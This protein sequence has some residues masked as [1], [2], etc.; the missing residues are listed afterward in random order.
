MPILLIC[1]VL[2]SLSI[3]PA[4]AVDINLWH[5][6]SAAEPT[7]ASGFIRAKAKNARYLTIDTQELNQL[8]MR[9]KQ[10]KR[11]QI[12]GINGAMFEF[13]LRP[14]PVMSTAL[15]AHYPKMMSYSGHQVGNVSNHGRFS[16][17]PTGLFGF[18][19]LHGEWILLSPQSNVAG[20]NYIA[21]RYADALPL[22]TDD[23]EP[24]KQNAEPDFLLTNEIEQRTDL[25]Q[26]FAPTGEQIRT[27][28]LAISTTG[29]YAQKLGG[30]KAAV[31]EEM[32]IMVNR[33]NQILLG[34]LAIQFELVDTQN[35]IF[36]D[37]AS[38]PYTN[39]DAA[40]DV[41]STQS[42]L[43]NAVGSAN[44]D[45]GHLFSTNGGGLAAVSGICRTDSKGTATSGANNPRGERFYIDY[46]IHEMG[47]QLGA[48]HTFNA[49]DQRTCDDSQRSASSA[50][51]PGSGSTIMSYAGL[52]SGQN[53][54]DNSDPYFHAGSIAEIRS[55]IDNSSRQSCGTLS[56]AN[57]AIPQIQLTKT[58]YTIP[59]NS[60]FVLTATATD[61]DLEPLIYNW[62]QVDAGGKNGGTANASE[63]SS[64]NGSN[65]LFRSFPAS[66]ISQRYFPQLGSVLNQQLSQGEV[67]PST[68]RTLTMRLTV[69]DNRG[70][71]NSADVSVSVV[72]NQQTFEFNSPLGAMTWPSFSQ[73]TLFWNVAQTT[74]P[75]INCNKVDILLSANSEREFSYTLASGVNNDGEQHV[76][77]PNID[78]NTVRLMLLCSDNVFY[79]LNDSDISITPSTPIQ[80][81]IN[82]QTTINISED[83]SREVTLADL[84]IEDADSSYPDDF[85][86]LLESGANYRLVGN[87]LTPAENFNGQLFV[88]LRVN[89][90]LQNSELFALTID[91]TAVND[92]P[93]GVNDSASLVQ[94]SPA[95]L[96]DVL[97]N[98]SDIEG[99]SLSIVA[100][101]YAGRST[102]SIVNQQIS[103]Q[104]ANGFSGNESIIYTLSDGQLTSIASLNITVT[105]LTPPPTSP[106]TNSNGGGG[107]LYQLLIFMLISLSIKGLNLRFKEHHE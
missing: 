10:A 15:A 50:F 98:D 85:T 105:V 56:T 90:G 88:N 29:E 60:A 59:A 91:V 35:V 36:I 42:T 54:Q 12:P 107:S 58:S 106:S 19:R 86:L 3:M 21:Y 47:H 92:P 22:D 4:V 16:L 14:S 1:L 61:D 95:T 34:D 81:K 65:P 77:L 5:E 104:S 80:P 68:E 7:L 76:Q 100:I 41:E 89:D 38:D 9:L 78:S 48:R 99:A 101:E 33:I 43:D 37:A 27:Y 64:D 13:E 70:G 71:V 40:S 18:Y 96:F 79:A 84:S 8:Q 72:N 74:Q 17:S 63:M 6:T 46:V 24:A 39:N 82:G 49:L 69:R 11:L 94:N 53:I 62:E 75:P 20:Q 23:N 87:V 32:M 73:Q 44:Y 66:S 102:V 97:N 52:C 93:I 51:E 67:Y 45:I 83:S 57:N 2:L 103:Y 26:K 30:S 28:R 55:I 31:V 25:Q